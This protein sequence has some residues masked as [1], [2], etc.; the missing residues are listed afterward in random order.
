MKHIILAADDNYAIPC[1]VTATSILSNNNPNEYAIHILT[2]GFNEGNIGIFRKLKA[3]FR[4]ATIEITEI[5]NSILKDAVISERFPFSAFFRI[6][7]PSLFSFDRALYLDSD[8]VVTGNIGELWDIDIENKACCMV[9][10]QACEDITLHNRIRI[11]TPYYNS[12]VLFMNLNFWREKRIDELLLEYMR[13]YPERCLYPDQDAIN[14]NLADY[15]LPL[16]YRYNVQ[17]RWYEPKEWWLMHY[18]KWDAI[19]RAKE[20]PIIIH[21]TGVWK[22]WT[23]ACSHPLA[24]LF[25]RYK[26]LIIEKASKENCSFE[27]KQREKVKTEKRKKH[28]HIRRANLFAIL[29]GIETLIF[30]LYV[31]FVSKGA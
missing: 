12:G 28:K 9:E 22:P 4:N 16:D 31:Y 20:T 8:I 29:L 18:N 5:D 30:I 3:K 14:A 19:E 7:V 17:E 26:S 13:N 27:N 23:E 11:F 21:Y 2:Q 15:I 6:L 10:D 24:A 1:F 25:D